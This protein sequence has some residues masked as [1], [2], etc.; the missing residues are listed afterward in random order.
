MNVF[1]TEFWKNYKGVDLFPFA[2]L[3]PQISLVTFLSLWKEML[4]EPE[5]V[6]KS[7]LELLDR[8]AQLNK[9]FLSGLSE[10]DIKLEYNPEKQKFEDL[11]F[12]KSPALT[13]VNN[14]HE[15][16]SKWILDTLEDFD[17]IDPK[18][19][20]SAKFF[21]KQYIDM[22]SPKNFPILNGDFW[23]ETLATS[24]NNIQKGLELLLKDFQKGAISTTDEE[25]FKVG[26]NLANTKGEVI[27]QNDIIELIQYSPTTEQVFAKPILFVPPWIN[28]FYIL[29]L[30]QDMSFVKWT[31]DRGFT[32]FI[33][34]WVNP[35]KKYKDT[36]FE[37]YMSSGLMAAIDK[38][39]DTTKAKSLHA[40]GYCVGGTLI[41]CYLAYLASPFCKHRPKA[42]IDSATLL[43]TLLDFKNAGDLAIFMADIYLKAINVQSEEK[44]FLDGKVMFNTFSTLK[45]NDMIWRYVRNSYM[46]G[47]KPPAHEILF[48][49]ADSTNI[50]KAMEMFLARD[51]YKDNIIKEGKLS[52]FGAPIDMKRIKTPLYM[53]PMQKDHLVPW[54]AMYD[55]I[56]MFDTAIR[57]VLGGSG[58]VAGIINPPA[59]KK[60]C[61]WVNDE[62]LKSA[63]E[64][65]D[66]AKKFNGSWWEDWISWLKPF[67][68]EMIPKRE[69][70]KSIRPA[71]GIYVQRGEQP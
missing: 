3:N 6:K 49:N 58:H 31:V 34:S 28:K 64:W 69:I 33:I 70:K 25:H 50:T 2:V 53:I 63:D 9:D 37:D 32:V 20:H 17:N 10:K 61:Y 62:I 16:T 26:E 44:G 45:A 57:F 14:F 60:Y 59:R 43:T 7:Q 23:K 52:L 36:G 46:L 39:Y 67:M 42:K 30:N 38:I 12:N 55:S 56:S 18:L 5:K 47:Q 13:F 11:D 48:W 41:S 15:V 24:G 40:I 8:L 27:F 51:L 71:P 4:A 68:G 66:A 29:D 22:M 19:M 65:L 1:D 21:A 35:D 54:K